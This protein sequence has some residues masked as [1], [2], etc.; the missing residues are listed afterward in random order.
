MHVSVLSMCWCPRS[1]EGALDL[2]ELELPAVVLHLMWVLGN[3]ADNKA[4][5]QNLVPLQE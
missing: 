3:K 4:G 2:L 1:A 5:K